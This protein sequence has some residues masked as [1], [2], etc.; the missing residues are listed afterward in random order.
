M[1]RPLVHEVHELFTD[2]LPGMTKALPDPAKKKQP[3]PA[4]RDG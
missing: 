2:F 3:G 1:L 4:E